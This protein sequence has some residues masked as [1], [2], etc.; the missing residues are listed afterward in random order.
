MVEKSK[1]KYFM[2]YEKLYEFQISVHMFCWNIV[3][4]VYLHTVYGCFLATTVELSSW[5]K[6]LMVYIYYL[7]LY[8]ISLLIPDLEHPK[9]QFWIRLCLCKNLMRMLD[10]KENK[11]T[12]QRIPNSQRDGGV[13]CQTLLSSQMTLSHFSWPFRNKE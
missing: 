2:M 5:T 3:M 8:R 11:G 6:D 9:N 13:W 4:L 1:E 7:P 10:M 12:S